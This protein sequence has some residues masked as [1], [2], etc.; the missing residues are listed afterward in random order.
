M[1]GGWSLP[2]VATVAV[3]LAA[4]T[5]F[6]QEQRLRYDPDS[7]AGKEYAIPLEDAREQ[8][9]RSRGGDR[10]LQPGDRTAVPDAGATGSSAESQLFGAGISPRAGGS[11]RGAPAA[12]RSPGPRDSVAG[13]RPDVEPARTGKSRAESSDVSGTGVGVGS[14]AAILV[15]AGLLTM[16]LRRRGRTP[17]DTTDQ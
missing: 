17:R 16:L 11:A 7:P 2:A 6:A 1:I 4:P 10:G 14:A 13:E 5:S 15:L 8:G 3:L 9:A 12:R